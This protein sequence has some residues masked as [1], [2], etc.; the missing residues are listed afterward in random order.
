MRTPHT[1]VV[2]L[3]RQQVLDGDAAAPPAVETAVGEAVAAS[4]SA[5]VTPEEAAA[6]IEVAD[7]AMARRIRG[8]DVLTTPP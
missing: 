2:R 3:S 6:A 5:R 8:L 4:A 1:A 7:L